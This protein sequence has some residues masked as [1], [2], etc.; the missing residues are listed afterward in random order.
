[1]G[2]DEGSGTIVIYHTVNDALAYIYVVAHLA[3]VKCMM[4]WIHK[5]LNAEPNVQGNCIT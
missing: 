4:N 1:M 5:S 3:A 2:I